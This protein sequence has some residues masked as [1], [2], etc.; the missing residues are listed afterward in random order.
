[1]TEKNFSDLNDFEDGVRDLARK[2]VS[3][4]I[5]KAKVANQIKA[6]I[7]NQ[8]TAQAVQRS[9][10]MLGP[11]LVSVRANKLAYKDVEQHLLNFGFSELMEFWQSFINAR[12]N[13]VNQQLVDLNCL[14]SDPISDLEIMDGDPHNGARQP[15]KV[16]TTLEADRRDYLYKSID[17][18]PMKMAHYLAA[19]VAEELGIIS[20]VDEVIKS[21]NNSYLRNFSLVS[22]PESQS[23]IERYY[24]AF[25][26]MV[27]I[28]SALEISDLHFE[29]I[30]AEKTGPKIIDIEFI[31]S[32]TQYQNTKWSYK[33][34]G[35]FEPETSPVGQIN[36]HQHISP[37]YR[38]ING[39]VQ[40]SH[41]EGKRSDLHIVYDSLG[42]P[43]NPLDFVKSIQR[44]ARDADKVLKGKNIGFDNALKEAMLPGH[45]IR[46]WM[47]GTAYYRILQIQLWLP[48]KKLQD[49]LALMRTKLKGKYSI[50]KDI[51]ENSKIAIIDAE[52]HDLVRGD[53]PYFWI[54]GMSGDLMHST[55][56][57]QKGFGLTTADALARRH[58]NWKVR[59]FKRDMNGII[60]RMQQFNT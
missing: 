47:R 19:T 31:L 22:K 15:L 39:N 60:N 37:T 51:V 26:A 7:V 41:L 58:K 8:L 56:L 46:C 21:T 45:K 16:T 10:E 28:A 12:C 30:I 3:P 54:D 5:E 2:F 33:N 14:L 29:N 50:N 11:T 18:T 43:V 35:L 23:E 9:R 44:G 38:L 1:M 25:G 27:S 48:G 4:M 32:N 24:Y 40:Y 57:I 59:D 55:G 6:Q 13:A 49:K 52:I 42:N 17:A 36:S 20:S 53:I 34:S